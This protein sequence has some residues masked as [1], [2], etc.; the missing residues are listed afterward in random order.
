MCV[1]VCA[2][3]YVSCAQ[4]TSP[5][6]HLCPLYQLHHRHL[7]HLYVFYLTEEAWSPTSEL[8]PPE[9]NLNHIKHCPTS[10]LYIPF[11]CVCVRACAV[12]NHIGSNTGL[13]I[14]KA[15][16]SELPEGGGQIVNIIMSILNT[17]SH[18]LMYIYQV[19][20]YVGPTRFQPRVGL[21]WCLYFVDA[22]SIQHTTNASRDTRLTAASNSHCLGN[23]GKH[24]KIP[25]APWYSGITWR[26][27]ISYHRFSAKI[28]FIHL[29]T[30]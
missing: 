6:Y 1:C 22:D 21:L 5:L 9:S 25:G 23:A 17:R 3:V 27:Q 7:A 28:I 15:E 24:S 11:Q 16:F 2:H 8:C 26:K 18:H 20:P 14:Y 10:I 30:D 19:G 12:E 29:P 13:R 4:T